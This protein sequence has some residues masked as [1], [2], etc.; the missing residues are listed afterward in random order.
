MKKKTILMP[1]YLL[2]EPADDG[3]ESWERESMTCVLI[4]DPN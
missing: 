1:H 3:A 2:S 4:Y